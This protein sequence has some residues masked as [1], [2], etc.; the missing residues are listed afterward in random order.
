MLPDE[1]GAADAVTKH[2]WGA[3][4][5]RRG[6]SGNDFIEERSA[7]HTRDRIAMRQNYVL[8]KVIHGWK[9]H[10]IFAGGLPGLLHDPAQRAI[11]PGCFFFDLAKHSLGKVQT[12]FSLV[13]S[14]HARSL[15]SVAI[16]CQGGGTA[17]H[18]CCI[19]SGFCVHVGQVD[20]TQ[21]LCF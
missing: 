3:R 16:G 18:I 20:L 9:L 7:I 10:H 15:M 13:G 4:F 2:D 19:G 6:R 1:S 11:L 12:L 14:S 21:A 17:L 8:V 5:V